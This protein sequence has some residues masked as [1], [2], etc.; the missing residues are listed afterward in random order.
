MGAMKHERQ[1]AV[2]IL[3]IWQEPSQ[4]TPPGEWRGSL[5]ALDGQGEWMFKSAA[6]LWQRLVENP[7]PS[8]PAKAAPEDPHPRG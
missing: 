2:Y 4:L 6:E 7:T 5:R 8:L 1:K 3:R